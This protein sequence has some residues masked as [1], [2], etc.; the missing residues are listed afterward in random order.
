MKNE[1]A[2]PGRNL[3]ATVY[4]FNDHFT[5]LSNFSKV[6]FHRMNSPFYSGEKWCVRKLGN[7]L[8]NSG[9]WEME[10]IPSE[11]DDEFYSRCRFDSLEDALKYYDI[12]TAML[13]A[14]DK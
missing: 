11:R 2:F 6:E 14:R 7:C 13:T 10:P 5:D 3:V 8:N 4:V 12:A 1:P 9:Q